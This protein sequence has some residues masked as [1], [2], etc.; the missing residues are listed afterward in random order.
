MDIA[1][2]YPHLPVIF[3]GLMGLSILVYV[4]LD[5]YDLGVGILFAVAPDKDRDRMI[6]SISVT[7]P[8]ARVNASSA[9]RNGACRFASC[10]VSSALR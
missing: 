6:A 1:S 5:G 9:R 8:S 10:C 3:A 7:R 2:L 4:V